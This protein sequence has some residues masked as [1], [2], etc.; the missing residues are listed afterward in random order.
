MCVAAL[1]GRT[2]VVGILLSRCGYTPDCPD[3]CGATPLMDALREGCVP[4]A[5]LLI[6][7]HQVTLQLTV[8]SSIG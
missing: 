2:E 8:F 4:I 7:K 1:H 6:H 3:S 5:Q